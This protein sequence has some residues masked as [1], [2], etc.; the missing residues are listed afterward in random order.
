MVGSSLQHEGLTPPD[1]RQ[2]AWP[3][4]ESGSRICVGRGTRTGWVGG[5]KGTTTYSAYECGR[6]VEGQNSAEME[7]LFDELAK[8]IRLAPS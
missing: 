6:F 4:M 2:L 7:A 3:F 8:S 5:E 1:L